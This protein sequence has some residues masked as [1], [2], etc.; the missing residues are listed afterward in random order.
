MDCNGPAGPPA[1]DDI[2]DLVP[3]TLLQLWDRLGLVVRCAYHPY[4]ACPLRRYL[5]VGQRVIDA[6][7]LPALRVHRRVFELL[8]Q[9]ARDEALPGFW[10]AACVDH[11][12]LPLARLQEL[13]A[14]HDPIAGGALQ[15]TR[16]QVREALARRAD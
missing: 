15:S 7:A 10:R 6:D 9:T 3:A 5:E 8:L 16:G 14:H 4:C 11:A 13:L 1:H 12:V 2:A